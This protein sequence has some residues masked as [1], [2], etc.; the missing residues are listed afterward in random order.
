MNLFEKYH[1]VK[2]GI[3]FDTKKLCCCGHTV[4]LNENVCPH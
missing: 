1:I 2:Y 3:K 4:E